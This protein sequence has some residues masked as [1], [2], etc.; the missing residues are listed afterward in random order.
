[1]NISRPWTDEE[2]KYLLANYGN[3]PTMEVSRTLNRWHGNVTARARKFGLVSIKQTARAAIRHDYFSVIDSPVKAY[4]LGLLASDGWVTKNEICIKLSAK[5]SELVQLVRDEL[6][7]RHRITSVG[8]CVFFRVVSQQMRQDLAIL[9]I[10]PRKS[11]ILRYPA[12]LPPQF[13]NSFILGCFDGDGCLNRYGENRRYWRWSLTSGSSMFLTS[14]KMR[15]RDATD[16][17]GSGP[18]FQTA[19]GRAQV[20][21]YTCSRVPPV[22][23]WLHAALPGLARK[24]L[25]GER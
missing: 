7:P 3:L 14:V 17:Q 22:D 6:A 21:Y 25:P 15:I 5:D 23:T 8:T 10:V 11:L 19:Q 9:G 20:L 2:D 13:D 16:I 4:V 12:S 18:S 1:M 24:R